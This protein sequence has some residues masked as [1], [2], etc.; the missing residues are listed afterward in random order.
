MRNTT[1]PIL[2]AL[3]A[4]LLCGRLLPDRSPKTA[5]GERL[6]VAREIQPGRKHWQHGMR[7]GATRMRPD[8]VHQDKEVE[9][10]AAELGNDAAE[11]ATRFA[12]LRSF[13]EREQFLASLVETFGRNQPLK[14]LDFLASLPASRL[15]NAALE[16]G[17]TMLAESDAKTA[18][19]LVGKYLQGFDAHNAV[20]EIAEIWAQKQPGEALQWANQNLNRSQRTALLE[21]MVASIAQNDPGH[22]RELV[23]QLALQGPDAQTATRALAG[24][25]AQTD[26]A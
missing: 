20:L 16:H 4:G 25:W 11:W 17:L 10:L 8:T 18:L 19:E 12:S 21:K 1:L 6:D 13:R 15:R 2:I 23:A 7:N 9:E 5:T 26:P 14:V 22:A 3:A 24:I